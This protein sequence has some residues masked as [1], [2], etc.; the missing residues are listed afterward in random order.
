LLKADTQIYVDDFGTGYSGLSQIAHLPLD[1]LKIDRAFVAGMNISAEHM[2]IVST[3]ISLAK[4]LRITVVAEGVET[5][6][7]A[8]RLHA[9]GC[10]EA[11]GYVFTR[12]MPADITS[13]LPTLPVSCGAFD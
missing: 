3:I 2:A 8:V 6:E 5:E 10:G 4:A 7:Q 13:L 11:Q 9:L 12:P 1:V